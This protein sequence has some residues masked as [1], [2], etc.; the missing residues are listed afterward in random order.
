MRYDIGNILN[1]Y[2]ITQVGIIGFCW[3]GKV[4]TLASTEFPS[5][6]VAELV[7][8]SSVSAEIIETGDTPMYLF[9][10]LDDPDMVR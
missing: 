10:C 6:K 8:S 5:I 9:S 7:H 3:G 2:A 1:F 4:S